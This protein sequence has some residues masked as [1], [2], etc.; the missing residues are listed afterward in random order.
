MQGLAK[1][2]YLQRIDLSTTSW[3]RGPELCSLA[4]GTV[5]QTR[6]L[7]FYSIEAGV[8]PNAKRRVLARSN[9]NLGTEHVDVTCSLCR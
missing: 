1:Y 8:H 3:P 9:P 7:F 5:N 2:R 6:S 4:N